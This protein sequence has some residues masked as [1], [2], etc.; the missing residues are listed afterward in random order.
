MRLYH[1]RDST[2][3][4]CSS[5][6]GRAF[7]VGIVRLR[8]QPINIYVEGVETTFVISTLCLISVTLWWG[9]GGGVVGA[10]NYPSDTF[11]CIV[12]PLV[13]FYSQL[14]YRYNI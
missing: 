2:T 14:R 9:G 12:V 8:G 10:G 13:L 5:N 11:P 4:T 3:I 7:V 1:I 6:S